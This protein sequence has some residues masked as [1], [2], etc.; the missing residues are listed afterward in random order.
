LLHPLRFDADLSPHFIHHFFGDGFALVGSGI[1]GVDDI[2]GL[3]M[4]FLDSILN[5]TDLFH[6]IL[7]KDFLAFNASNSCRPATVID[8]GDIV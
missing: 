5:G 2:L 7:E 8:E 6:H 3:L 1:Q 4:K